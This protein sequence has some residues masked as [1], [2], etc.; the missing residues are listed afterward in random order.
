MPHLPPTAISRLLEQLSGLEDPRQ[1][2]KVLYPL[3][4]ILLLGLASS[5]AGADDVVERV[6][7]AK[8]NADFLRRYYPYARGIPSHDTVSD[9]FNAL[10]ATLFSELFMSWTNSLSAQEGDLLNID[11]K[12]SR[13]SGGNGQPPRLAAPA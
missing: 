9:V 12:T 3:P 4:E 11:G 10:N 1:P 6:R 8:L 5:L 2:A 13:R 7:W